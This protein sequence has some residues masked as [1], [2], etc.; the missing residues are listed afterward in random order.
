[1]SIIVQDEAIWD[2]SRSPT[3]DIGQG[4][5]AYIR[6]AGN[7]CYDSYTDFGVNISS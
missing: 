7:H 1:M 2:L 3:T 4:L 5:F 6:R